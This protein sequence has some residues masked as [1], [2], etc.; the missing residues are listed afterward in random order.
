[1]LGSN[2]LTGYFFNNLLQV[3]V[4]NKVT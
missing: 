3:T 1:V 4:V 2:L